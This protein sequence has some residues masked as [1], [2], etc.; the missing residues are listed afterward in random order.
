MKPVI[1]VVLD[2][3]GMAPPSPGNAIFNAHPNFINSLFYSYPNTQLKANGEDVGL[4]HG[5]VGNTEVGHV[6][7]GAGKI[8]Y[9]SLPRI[10]LSIA[11]SS[12]DKNPAFVQALEH[13]KKTGGKLHLMGL[14]SSGAVHSCI[15][16]LYA[17]LHFCKKNELNEVFIHAFTDGRDS[18]PRMAKNYLQ[19]V[20]DKV[21]ELK[22]GTI[23]SVCGRYYAMDRDKRWERTEKAYL[24]LTE[25][26]GKKATNWQEAIDISY[27]DGKTD[28]FIEPTNIPFNGKFIT[29]D[30]GDAVIFFNFR[31]DRPRQ[32]T[33]AFVLD[34]F[35]NGANKSAYDPFAY[36]YSHMNPGMVA[37][38]FQPPFLRKPKI[39]DLYFATMTEYEVGLPTQVAFR[40]QQ[41]DITLGMVVSQNNMRQLRMSE[42][43]KERFV[44][45]YMNGLREPPYPF[46]D[47]III[48]SPKVLTYDLK[49]E[50][51]AVEIT[52]TLISKLPSKKY[53][54]ILVNYANADMVGH[55]GN[56][57]AGIKAI[58]TLDSCMRRLINTAL[59]SGYVVLITADHGNAEVM[60]DPMTGEID[61]EHNGSPVPFI[62]V[63]SEYMNRPMK[64][65]KGI[66]ADI[67][68]TILNLL[69]LEK[70]SQ[71][72]GRDLIDELTI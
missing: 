12:F 29:V 15:E 7:I 49:P 41:V 53:Q 47:R 67:A 2:G 38:V 64:L 8:V 14:I 70:P 30:K 54:F 34:D 50:M 9:Q 55:T 57:E 63:D 59:A 23:V 71:M 33:K 3:F 16:H 69:K 72:T 37:T 62:Y 24:C 60:I 48:P 18:P 21:D 32:L 17:L 20:Q 68:P 31:I 42:S 43:E 13:L 5:E 44:T 40:P 66:L 25:A 35:A 11:D 52:D 58:S 39:Q 6:N 46:E 45:Y 65:Q 36:K 10:N 56:L 26:V 22:I 19:S 4:P 51:S 61:T 1:L 28:E 27:K